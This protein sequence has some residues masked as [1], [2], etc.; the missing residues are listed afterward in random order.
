MFKLMKLDSILIQPIY[1]KFI[2][3]L[4]FNSIKLFISTFH[5]FIYSHY[6]RI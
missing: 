3:H 5:N 1:F 6:L 2:S 4:V